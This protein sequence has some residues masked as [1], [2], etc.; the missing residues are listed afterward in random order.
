MDNCCFP[1]FLD[2]SEM[3]CP[4]REFTIPEDIEFDQFLN[5]SLPCSS[6]PNSLSSSRCASVDFDT[7][8]EPSVESTSFRTSVDLGFE[9]TTE[10]TP[11]SVPGGDVLAG[12]TAMTAF[13]SLLQSTLFIEGGYQM[14]STVIKDSGALEHPVTSASI[15][16]T[17]FAPSQLQYSNNAPI[18][19]LTSD[20]KHGQQFLL[21]TMKSSK[22]IQDHEAPANLAHVSLSSVLDNSG[23]F[24]ATSLP[25]VTAPCHWLGAAPLL[26]PSSDILAFSDCIEQQA[27]STTQLPLLLPPLLMPSLVTSSSPLSPSSPSSQDIL[28]G[29]AQSIFINP[30]EPYTLSDKTLL[31]DLKAN[32][33]YTENQMNPE[34]TAIAMANSTLKHLST[35]NDAFSYNSGIQGLFTDFSYSNIPA[36]HNG[37]ESE[38]RFVQEFLTPPLTMTSWTSSDEPAAQAL[39]IP[40]TEASVLMLYR[41]N[42]L[43]Q[44]GPCNIGHVGYMSPQRINKN[45]TSLKTRSN[46]NSRK[47]FSMKKITDCAHYRPRNA[48]FMFRGFVSRLQQYSGLHYNLHRQQKK[49]NH[50]DDSHSN[51][52]NGSDVALMSSPCSPLASSSPPTFSLPPQSLSPSSPSLP[53]PAPP[54][55][56]LASAILDPG[57]NILPPTADT[58]SDFKETESV[59]CGM[60][61]TKVSISCGKIW[62]S[63]CFEACGPGGCPNCRMRSLFGQA[64][65]FLKLRQAEI[66]RQI[67][68]SESITTATL[69]EKNIPL[70]SPSSLPSTTKMMNTSISDNDSESQ[71]NTY[72]ALTAGHL[73]IMSLE[74]SFNWEEFTQLYYESDLFKW[75]RNHYLGTNGVL[76][77]EAMKHVW[78]ENELAYEKAFVEGAR[79]RIL[80]E[81]GSK[82]LGQRIRRTKLK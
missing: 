61:Q 64:S 22:F 3:A 36:K 65:S 30:F 56:S 71:K 57:E 59:G 20:C 77:L 12:T 14:G 47:P 31:D 10:R 78:M 43:N 7:S 32:A 41:P 38:L 63:E 1:D 52:K 29:R 75:H 17:D 72:V 28:S 70:L 9:Q 13:D 60:T 51:N 55:Q 6:L 73:A 46:I 40:E 48:F 76:D 4:K 68:F 23:P 66:E 45:R 34:T 35:Q 25:C 26:A 69:L 21:S 37:L 16:G 54:L 67:E 74:N 53:L 11:P 15:P 81:G 5:A 80:Q 2:F 50:D 42:E 18:P 19:V 58:S 49:G 33:P 8:P 27:L 82:K 39:V 24:A 62:S 44:N 79:K